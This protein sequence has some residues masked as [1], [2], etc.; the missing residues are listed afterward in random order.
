MIF[1]SK[2][3]LMRLKCMVFKIPGKYLVDSSEVA[4]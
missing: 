1:F 4:A 2:V 3:K